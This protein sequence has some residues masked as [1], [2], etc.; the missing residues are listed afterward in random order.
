[1]IINDNGIPE[2]FDKVASDIIRLNPIIDVIELFPNGVL[3]YVYPFQTNES[4][5]D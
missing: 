1:M 5:L 2:D 3:K 4:V